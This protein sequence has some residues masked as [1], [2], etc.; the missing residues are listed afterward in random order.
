MNDEQMERYLAG[1]MPERE[2]VEFERKIVENPE[3]SEQLYADSQIR[4]ALEAAAE[5]KRRAREPA[6][7]SESRPWWHLPVLRWGVP[8][9]AV[10][11]V[12]IFAIV[13]RGPNGPTPREVFRGAE[14]GFVALS[15]RGDVGEPPTRFVWTSH[16][17]AVQYRFELFDAASNRV[18]T[19][20][21]ADTTVQVFVTGPAASEGFWTVTPL[22]QNL[23]GV[24]ET[25]LTRYRVTTR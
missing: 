4:V 17:G 14:A 25:I 10:A 21:T 12:A 9:V 5:E 1:E 8:A 23:A 3:L 15:P 7:T 2:R 20:V 11:I 24:G 13:D 22:D 19:S 6:P 16:P 18:H